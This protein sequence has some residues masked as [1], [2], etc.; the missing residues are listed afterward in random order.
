M[1]K[2]SSTVKVSS[3]YQIAIPSAARAELDIEAGDRLLVDV[4]DGVMILIPK[5]SNYVGHMAGLYREI[6][7]RVDTDKYLTD[8]REA[9]TE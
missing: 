3:R 8:E 9:W 7:E 4:Q 1:S 5:P 2:K 6:W